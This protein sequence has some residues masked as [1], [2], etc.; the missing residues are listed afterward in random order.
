MTLIDLE[1]DYLTPMYDDESH[2]S[3]NLPSDLEDL[4]LRRRIRSIAWV[5]SHESEQPEAYVDIFYG[6][7]K[8]GCLACVY[9]G[10]VGDA[11]VNIR[12]HAR[13]VHSAYYAPAGQRITLKAR[14]GTSGFQWVSMR[15]YIDLE[16]F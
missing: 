15:M 10:G 16:E 8:V 7:R 3:R 14:N 12:K 13:P 9:L 1:N 4:T 6:K 5:Y 11:V 2:A